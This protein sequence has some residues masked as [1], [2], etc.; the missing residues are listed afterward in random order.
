MWDFHLVLPIDVANILENIH[1]DS[2]EEGLHLLSV[3]IS[4]SDIRE[5]MKSISTSYSQYAL[6]KTKALEC[7]ISNVLLCIQY[8]N[9]HNSL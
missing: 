8:V 5:N 4:K 2:C 3:Y 1:R 7:F 6:R 9:D